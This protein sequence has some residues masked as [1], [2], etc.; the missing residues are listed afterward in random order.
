MS[1][2]PI[3][4]GSIKKVAISATGPTAWFR[5]DNKTNPF[6]LTT[7]VFKDGATSFVAVLE[8][9]MA[10]NP[11]T[12]TSEATLIHSAGSNI[13]DNSDFGFELPINAVRLNVSSLTGGNLAFI[14]LQAGT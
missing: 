5:V 4:P 6:Q 1:I 2:I 9:S 14:L 11:D 7:G 12:E 8:Y 13:T 10:D 3:T